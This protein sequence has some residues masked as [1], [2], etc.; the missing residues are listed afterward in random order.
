MCSSDLAISVPGYAATALI[1]LFFASLNSL[2]L[3]IIGI[4]VWRA[5]E[6]TKQRPQSV[7]SHCE[8]SEVWNPISIPKQFVNH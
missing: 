6:N 1:I 4:Y 8:R 2:G 3:G 7:V 5:F